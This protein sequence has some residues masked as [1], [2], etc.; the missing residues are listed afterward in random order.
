MNSHIKVFVQRFCS[1][2]PYLLLLN[3]LLHNALQMSSGMHGIGVFKRTLDIPDP[4]HQMLY[5]NF[6]PRTQIQR[7]YP[8]QSLIADLGVLHTLHVCTLET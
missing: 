6:G 1:C 2:S 4:H 7:I 3:N 8:N 5:K